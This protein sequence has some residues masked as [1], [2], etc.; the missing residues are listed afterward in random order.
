M[1]TPPS[2][3]IDVNAAKNILKKAFSTLGQSGTNA[4]G[5]LPSWLVGASL[6]AKGESMSPK[7]PPLASQESPDLKSG[8]CQ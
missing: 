7:V 6:L 8:E 2:T 1:A 4:W 3:L 5:D